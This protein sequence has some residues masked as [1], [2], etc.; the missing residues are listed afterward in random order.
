MSR[1]RW[2]LRDAAVAYASRGIPVLP[3]HHPL[4]HP[5]GL[6]PVPGDSQPAVARAGCSCRDP[7]CGQPGKHPLGTLVLHGLKEATCNR[8]RVLAWWTRHPQANIGL[9]TG[10]RFDVLDVDG[11]EGAH[12]IQELAAAHGLQSSGPLVRTGGGGWHYYLVPTGLGSVQPRELNHV[13]WRGLGGYVVAPPSRHASGHP[14]QWVVGCDLDTPLAEVPPPLRARLERQWPQR[15]VGPLELAATGAAPGD[16]YARAALT[17]ELARVAAAP[18]G[19]RNR[20]LWESTRNLYNLVATGALEHRE[21]DQALLAA[22]ERCG[23]LAE[24]PRQTHRTLASGRQVGLAHPGRPRQPTS[25]E[26]T[27]PSPPRPARA[28]GER[29]KGGR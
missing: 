3:L 23:L 14:Y 7:E 17:E 18:V 16:R 9:A 19:R 29:T 27:H 15:S 12:A 5:S 20:Q 1:P 11:P 4:P 25:P 2:E 26:R 21:V 28:A 22:A 13:D 10:H 24:E 6:Q 8:A